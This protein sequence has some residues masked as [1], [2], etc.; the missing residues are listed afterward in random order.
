MKH[1]LETIPHDKLMKG[2]L[3]SEFMECGCA[4][5]EFLAAEHQQAIASPVFF[6]AEAY[7]LG[8][9]QGVHQERARRKRKAEVLEAP[10][11][12]VDVLRGGD[13]A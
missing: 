4:L 3:L 2:V 10:T 8:I 1:L 5:K 13:A 9:R 11:A 7:V 6:A 12:T